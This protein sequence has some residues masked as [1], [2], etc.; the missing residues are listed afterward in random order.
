MSPINHESYSEIQ[1]KNPVVVLFNIDSDRFARLK[2]DSRKNRRKIRKMTSLSLRTS[3]KRR[4]R[5]TK[6]NENEVSRKDFRE[7]SKEKNLQ[8][9]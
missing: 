2:K 7:D 5:T 1:L 4:A 6:K 9:V 3:K 8:K